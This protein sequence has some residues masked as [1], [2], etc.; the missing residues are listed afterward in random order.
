[1]LPF[2]RNKLAS[3]EGSKDAGP[4]FLE[5]GGEGLSRIRIMRQCIPN[6]WLTCC[7]KFNTVCKQL[8]VYWNMLF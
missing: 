1:M 5:K 8:T 7:V 2:F 4:L 3:G 6:S